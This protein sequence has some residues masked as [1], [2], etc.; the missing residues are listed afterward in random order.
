MKKHP[1]SHL[2]E[3]DCYNCFGVYRFT[4]FSYTYLYKCRFFGKASIPVIFS[5]SIF[6]YYLGLC[7]PISG[8]H[9]ING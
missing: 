3:N 2:H 5:R 8:M 6:T 4:L 1:S 9:R 7:I